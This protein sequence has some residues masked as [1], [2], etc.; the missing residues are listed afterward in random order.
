M[1]SFLI[2]S[3]IIVVVLLFAGVIFEQYSRWRLERTAFNGKIFVEINGKPL[4]YV[5]KGHGNC[6]IVFQS[7]M[8]SSHRVWE[9]IQDSISPHA[10]TIS[11]DRNGLMLSEDTGIPVTNDHISHELQ[12]LLEKTKCPKPYILV[13]HSMA[14]VYLRPFIR[15]NV[16]D[17]SGIILA[18]AANPKL[19]KE[20]SPE[21]LKALRIPPDW[22]IK[23]VVN[24]GIYRAVF[25]F[26]PISRE[27]PFA[28]PLHRQERDFF[29]RSYHKVLE[30][31][32]NDSLNFKDAEKYPS[33]GDIPLTVI[34][35]TSEVRYAGIKKSSIK[36]EFRLLVNEGQHELLKLSSNSQLVKAQNSGHLLQINDKELLIKEINK[37]LKNQCFY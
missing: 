30:E 14:S 16:Q 6:T 3:L 26:I 10:V 11:Y 4:H 15:R 31:L 35:G 21:L 22:L 24:T 25:S 28:H 33:F 7:G 8:G 37:M 17:I 23:S 9:E 5:K 20:A 18:E 12:L 34:M 2:W 13:G 19:A 32:K 1:L 27:I 36:D 29:Y